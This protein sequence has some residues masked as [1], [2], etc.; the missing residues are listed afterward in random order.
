M[1]K[2]IKGQIDKIRSLMRTKDWKKAYKESLFRFNNSHDPDLKEILIE[3]H[4]EW[5]KS[6][7]SNKDFEQGK[8]EIR[9]FLTFT[10]LPEKYYEEATSLF[11]RLGISDLLPESCRNTLQEDDIQLQ[12]VDNAICDQSKNEDLSPELQL[13]IKL[14]LDTLE[15]IASK[16]DT[17]VLLPLK[18]ISFQSP[19]SEWVLFIRGLLEWYQQDQKIVPQSW[20]R[21]KKNRIPYKI[22]QNLLSSFQKTDN[23]SGEN[24]NMVQDWR[25]YPGK[26]DQKNN[27]WKRYQLQMFLYS[28]LVNLEKLL[29][30]ESYSK[31]IYCFN[32][33]KNELK[34]YN[35]YY[36][37]RVFSYVLKTLAK[38]ALA[39]TI[40]SFIKQC[41]P[42][43][44]DPYGNRAI[45]LSI[46]LIPGN[47][48]YENIDNIYEIKNREI[49]QAFNKS[50]ESLEN[51]IEDINSI[52]EIPSEYKARIQAI[53]FDKLALYHKIMLDTLVCEIKCGEDIDGEDTH[54]EDTMDNKKYLLLK[55]KIQATMEYYFKR[56]LECD[57]E[58]LKTYQ[59]YYEYLKDYDVEHSI[60]FLTE[61]VQVF[62]REIFFTLILIRI[63]YQKNNYAKLDL[64]LK[65]SLEYFPN[66]K[67]IL[68][69]A[70][71]RSIAHIHQ[72]L[73]NSKPKEALLLLDNFDKIA[74][75]F[76]DFSSLL[77]ALA[78]R[79]IAFCM[80]GQEKM[81]E[82]LLN[83]LKKYTNNI[84]KKMPVCIAILSLAMTLNYES[85]IPKIVE[86]FVHDELNG[87][88]NAQS[89]ACLAAW[90]LYC[91]KTP[92]LKM[93]FKKSFEKD[94]RNFILR[95]INIKWTSERY[96]ENMCV[97]LVYMYYIFDSSFYDIDKCK[98]IY[99]RIAK[100]YPDMFFVKVINVMEYGHSARLPFYLDANFSS[101][102][103][104]ND[105]LKK[106]IEESES[107]PTFY[108]MKIKDFL[109]KKSKYYHNKYFN[110]ANNEFDD[111][112]DSYD[113]DDY[114]DDYEDDYDDEI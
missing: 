87:N 75:T 24:H 64:L 22:V 2:K 46:C 28:G 55:P 69:M 44:Y 63:Y 97:F 82:S 93:V 30:Q 94:V 29:Q 79:Y 74:D 34:S 60:S 43:P 5:I 19:C 110:L 71:L 101:F 52:T 1:N 50:I 56:A 89:A 70:R 40:K 26:Q 83:N 78:Y 68:Y 111:D 65:Q 61:A 10:P 96:A 17:E 23:E 81:A 99:Q 27:K 98:K 20:D 104:Y 85:R 62:P 8:N 54:N 49:P 36:F 103:S 7:I 72:C 92:K 106:C 58:Y 42:L 67:D 107:Y 73:Q 108:I 102:V 12:L 16:E 95:S 4:W 3:S 105:G 14:I 48:N 41:L 32:T 84:N 57:K 38:T 90:D 11:I 112:Y 9:A 80:D 88:A 76:F 51:Y 18:K 66:N 59:F 21:L 53:I 91:R 77:C 37:D 39:E 33:L 31:A 86:Q 35:P 13:E 45:G 109:E 114:Y 100:A 47:D 113:D 25:Y 6:L 15:K